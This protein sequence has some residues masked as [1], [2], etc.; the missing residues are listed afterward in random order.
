MRI[1]TPERFMFDEGREL[2]RL[3]LKITLLSGELE[4]LKKQKQTER[5]RA[6]LHELQKREAELE[7][8]L[9]FVRLEEKV[10]TDSMWR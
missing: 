9:R 10:I 6:R 8:L 2:D 3:E 4:E 5:K 1:E 7:Q